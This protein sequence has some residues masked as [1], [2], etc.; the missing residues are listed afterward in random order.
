MEEN[1]EHHDDDDDNNNNIFMCKICGKSLSNRRSLGGH[2][3]S[4]MTTIRDLQ[5]KK[6]GFEGNV[7]VGCYGLRENPKKSR[8][9]SDLDSSGSS[10]HSKQGKHCQECGKIFKSPRALFGHMRCH[11]NR[12]KFSSKFSW[13]NCSSNSKQKIVLESLSDT[14]DVAIPRKRK[15]SERSRH[16]FTSIPFVSE[17]QDEVEEAALCLMMLCRDVRGWDRF[18]SITESSENNSLIPGGEDKDEMCCGGKDLELKNFEELKLDSYVSVSVNEEEA[19]KSCDFGCAFTVNG[20]GKLELECSVDGF[21]WADEF[22]K[23]ELDTEVEEF[24]EMEKNTS[25]V[26]LNEAYLSPMKCGSVKRNDSNDHEVE[27]DSCNEP[28]CSPTIDSEI[29]ESNQKKGAYE[30]YSCKKAFRTHQALGGHRAG[31]KR[32]R[33]CLVSK[34]EGCEKEV[35]IN[36]F[37]DIEANCELVPLDYS[38]SLDGQQVCGRAESVCYDAKK[39]KIHECPTCLKMFS[40]GQALGGHK[41]AHFV[42]SSDTKP[43]ETTPT[44]LE[45][46]DI[47][48]IAMMNLA[49]HAPLAEGTNGH[50][51][52]SP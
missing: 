47:H 31:R 23:S 21:P 45:F 35:K 12:E 52:L 50:G 43:K 5:T 34:F 4:H 44:K 13:N 36:L 22:K 33:T 2:M 48:D 11:P 28:S 41:R 14:S 18:N 19:S 1:Q 27:A 6:T 40:T 8:K 49:V 16:K 32:G 10:K 30:C 26:E 3:R 9:F 37:T 24:S 46:G 7:H 42:L 51:G 25:K 29:L 38:K 39:S 17:S 15:R 20:N